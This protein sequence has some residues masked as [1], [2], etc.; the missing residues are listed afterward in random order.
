MRASNYIV[1]TIFLFLSFNSYSL[2]DY[3]DYDDTPTPRKRSV[4]KSSPVVSKAKAKTSSRAQGSSRKY[5]DFQASFSHA[6]YDTSERSGKY[7]RL[8]LKATLATNYDFYVDVEYPM[9]S[10]RISET[11]VDTSYQAG[12]PL[13]V[14]GLNWLQFGG[15]HLDMEAGARFKGS[16]EFASQ[17]TDKILGV[18][19]SKRFN[20]VALSFGYHYT[21]TGSS[22]SETES[23]IGNISRVKFE[24]GW[25]VSSDIALMIK[26]QNTTINASDDLGRVNRLDESIKFSTITPRLQLRMAP[27]V[28]LFMQATFRMRRPKLALTSSNLGL[29]HVD[30]LYGNTLSA[31]LGFDI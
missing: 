13:L 15:I 23:D 27:S 6:E 26:A 28:K 22:D 12:N 8:D 18:S 2:V 10:G 24:A 29:W 31:G 20:N 4:R 3:T 5:I 9:Y 19:S 17:R 25:V 1:T 11:Q 14:V 16:S 30:G 7:D 21:F